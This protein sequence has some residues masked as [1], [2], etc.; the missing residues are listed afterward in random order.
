MKTD[1]TWSWS[2]T[3]ILLAALHTKCELPYALWQLLSKASL[4]SVEQTVKMRHV[5]FADGKCQ[6]SQHFITCPEA[7]QHQDA[8]SPSPV[9]LTG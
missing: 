5:N 2:Q 8:L 9:A 1:R 6:T 7:A 4:A 3:A